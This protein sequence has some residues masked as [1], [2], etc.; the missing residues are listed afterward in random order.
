MKLLIFIFTILISCTACNSNS[1]NPDSPDSD[2]DSPDLDHDSHDLHDLDKDTE[3]VDEEP[4][5][6]PDETGEDVLNCIPVPET[7]DELCFG[8]RATGETCSLPGD[9]IFFTD[10]LIAQNVPGYYLQSPVGVSDSYYFYVRSF[11]DPGSHRIIYRCSRKTGRE[12]IIVENDPSMGDDGYLR[13]FD[14]EGKYIAFSYHSLLFHGSRDQTCYLGIMDGDWELK[15]IAGFESDC[16]EPQIRWP[17]VAYR[18]RTTGWIFI[19]D[20]RTGETRMLEGFKAS[21]HHIDQ[22]GKKMYINAVPGDS[23]EFVDHYL[24]KGPFRPVKTFKNLT[25]RFIVE[26]LIF[27]LLSLIKQPSLLDLNFYCMQ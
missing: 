3:T 8:V 12:E 19:Y 10:H 24:G 27:L 18:N 23:D 13:T 20:I 5:E 2:P 17:F 6:V 4:D 26:T 11:S 15:R 16:Y 7:G 21:Y 14:V 1:Q 9:G 22:A 25:K